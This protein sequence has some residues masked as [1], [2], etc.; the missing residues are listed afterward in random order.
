MTKTKNQVRVS[1]VGYSAFQVTGSMTLVETDSRKI[2]IEAGLVQGGTVLQDWQANTRKL[3]FKPSEITHIFVGH[4]HADH[5]L[6]I[7]RLFAMGCEAQIIAPTGTKALFEIMASDS[8]YII[9]KDAE[10]LSNSCGKPR[11]PFYTGK[12]VAN[13]TAHF[14]EYGLDV[15]VTLEEDLKFRF[16]PSGHLI[17]AAQIELWVTSGNHT[18]KIGYTSDLGANLP[19]RYINKFKPLEKCNLFIGECTYAREPRPVTPKDRRNDLAKIKSVIETTCIEQK[20][21]VL[22]PV[23]SLDRAQNMASFIYDMFRDAKDF[24]VPILIDSP[25]TIKMFGY[26]R[27]HASEEDQVYIAELM[28]WKNLIMIESYEE[29][30]RWMDSGKPCCILS[31]AGMLNA[32]RSRRWAASLLPHHNAHILF[33]GF[34]VENSLAS[35]IKNFPEQRTI[36][37][38]GKKVRNACSVTDLHSFSG[39][40]GRDDLLKYYSDI[41]AEKIALVHA[42]YDAKVEFAHDLQDAISEKNK[43]GRVVCVNRSTEILV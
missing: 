34:S 41:D 19:R 28:G 1:F 8:A 9:S 11:L 16:T 42:D 18:A 35:K 15:T 27:D 23:F 20:G 30:K 43:T 17:N 6:L 12:D 25:L 33:C 32:G 10:Y 7:P 3:P 24:D 21:R 39:H 4:A 40:M 36:S 37:I 31:S 13:A 38:D 29:S 5:M 2:L 14:A 22:I 26:M